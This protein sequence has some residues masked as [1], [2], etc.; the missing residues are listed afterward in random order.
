VLVSTAFSV[1]PVRLKLSHNVI[2]STAQ[3]SAVPLPNNLS[4][5]CVNQEV[6]I[7]PAYTQLVT[8]PAFQV[9]S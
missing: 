8:V 5:A 9:V 2:S 7:A 1:V 6:V 3:V 4:V